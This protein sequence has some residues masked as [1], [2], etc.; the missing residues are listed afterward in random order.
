[1]LFR[2]LQGLLNSVTV[3]N[4]F[5]ERTLCPELTLENLC[6][7]NGETFLEYLQLIL[8]SDLGGPMK[9]PKTIPNKLVDEYLSVDEEHGKKPGFRAFAAWLNVMRAKY[10]TLVF[11]EV[12]CVLVRTITHRR[13]SRL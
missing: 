2:S 12:F 1:M 8:P 6:A 13:F 5:R 7:R 9:A 11:R 3:W 10:I 4:A